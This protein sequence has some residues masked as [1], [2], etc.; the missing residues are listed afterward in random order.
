MQKEMIEKAKEECIKNGM[1][2]M[3][4]DG[5]LILLCEKSDDYEL[6]RKICKAYA[7]KS[8]FNIGTIFKNE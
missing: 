5:S 2:V 1:D 4:Q 3:I 6:F 8:G 7:E